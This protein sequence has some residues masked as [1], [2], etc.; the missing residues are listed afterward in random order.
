MAKE[1]S[2]APMTTGNFLTWLKDNLPVVVVSIFSIVLFIL[3]GFEGG[4]PQ[5]FNVLVTGGMWALLATGLALVFGVMNIPHF[6]HGESFMV[7]AY[8]AYFR[9]Y[10]TE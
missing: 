10:P 3:V 5:L 6:A 2:A 7:G 4:A 8:V 1:T 9:I